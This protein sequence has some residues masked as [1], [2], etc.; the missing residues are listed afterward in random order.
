MAMNI[1]N[2]RL[3][4]L[5]TSF[6]QIPVVPQLVSDLGLF[7]GRG[8][9]TS[10]A[11]V[12]RREQEFNLIPESEPGSPAEMVDRD[13][14]GVVTFQ[15]PEHKQMTPIYEED[16][17]DRR[18]FMSDNMPMPREEEELLALMKHRRRIDITYEALRVSALQGILLNSDGT[19]R[20]NFFTEFGV[21]QQTETFN[22]DVDTEEITDHCQSVHEKIDSAIGSADAWSGILALCDTAFF[23]AVRAH[24]LVKDKFVNV[25]DVAQLR[26]AGVGIR[27]EYGGIIFQSYHRSVTDSA[28]VSRKLIPANTALAIPLGTQTIFEEVWAPLSLRGLANTR[29]L[30]S[31]AWEQTDTD[32]PTKPTVLAT[33]MRPFPYV[34]RPDAVV[35]LV[36]T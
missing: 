6:E 16:I 22:L 28:G 34:T 29:G 26:D 15:I 35:K 7:K 32:D 18:A 31:Y 9:A 24:P 14:R 10:Q 21:S 23:N 3:R 4:E 11:A 8:I 30:R 12:E 1:D 27:F 17:Q 36:L 2:W 5:T 33:G 20:Y 25:P 19:T 13:R